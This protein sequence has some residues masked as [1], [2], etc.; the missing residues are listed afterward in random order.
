MARSRL[1][2]PVSDAND[3]LSDGGAIL[4]SFVQGEQLEFPL[5]LGFV[6]NILITDASVLDP[7]KG[8]TLEAKVIE[9]NN[10][11]NQ[12]TNPTAIKAG[13]IVTS[14]NVRVPY[15]AGVWNSGIL[16]LREDVVL[17]G[18]SYYKC[19]I[20]GASAINGTPGTTGSGWQATVPNKVYIQYP[21]EL[22]NDWTTKSFLTAE[23]S[24]YGFFELRVTEP[25]SAGSYSLGAAFVRTWK[26]VRGLVEILYS[27]TLSSDDL[28]AT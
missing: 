12:L 7:T 22:A 4:W 6:E 24:I 11:A 27:P 14:I 10:V 28:S 16:Y 19:L 1:I 3:L 9:A 13:G 2:D 20:A 18:G 25:V 8:Y 15:Y 5:T 21:N 26:P 17:Y 23:T